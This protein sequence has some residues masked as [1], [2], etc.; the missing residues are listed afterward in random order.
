MIEFSL[1]GHGFTIQEINGFIKGF[2][3]TKTS[4][5]SKSK[6]GASTKDV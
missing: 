6:D 3:L 2:I 4:S 1:G 5:K